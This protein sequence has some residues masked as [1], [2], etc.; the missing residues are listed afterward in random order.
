M[1]DLNIR[2]GAQLDSGVDAKIQKQL[3]DVKGLHL[4]VE[5]VT[6]SGKALEKIQSALNNSKVNL[7]I[8]SNLNG[9]NLQKQG[10]QLGQT[11]GQQITSG[12]NNT[13][14][15]GSFEK[16]FNP[17]SINT[18]A[19]EA[20]KYFQTIS[21]SVSVTENLGANNN[22][23]SFIVSLKNADGVVE[24]L[25]YNLQTLKDDD[26][27][28]TSKFFQYSGGNI[29]DN[30]VIQQ[31]TKI[32]AKADDLTLKLDKVKSAYSDINSPKAVK[33]NQHVSQLASQYDKVVQS[34]GSLR[35]ADDST[36]SA[37]TANVNKEI[38]SL[39][40]M[41][42]QF[43]NAEYAATS[44]R[45]KDISTIKVD[46][47][48]SLNTFVEKM[49]QS[50]N[51]TVD[52]QNKV[53]G[54]KTELSKVFDS[55]S[56]TG[57]LNKLSN[58][59]SEFDSVN[60]A[61]NTVG[62]AT[63]LQT[64]VDME[65]NKLKNLRQELESNGTITDG[66]R[67]KFDGLETSLNKV[68]TATG[69]TT[70]RA[71]MKSVQSDVDV[72]KNKFNELANAEKLA[73]QKT[74]VKSNIDEFLST[75]T[76]LTGELRNRFLELRTAID[77]VDDNKALA[78]VKTQLSTLK[79]EA[80]SAGMIGKSLGDTFKENI[81][82]FSNWFGIGTLVAGSVRAL[83]NM[84]QS[85]YDIDTAMTSL[86]KVTDETSQKY[87]QF[88]DGATT[89]AQELGRSVSSLVEQ[90]ATWAKLGFGIDDAAKLAQISSIYANVGEVDDNA[91]VSDLVTAM[92]AF[93]IQASDSITIVD[94]LN[95]LGNKFA[96]DSASLGEGLKNSASA[97][98][99][100]G[101]DIN[102]SLAMITGGTEIVQ[103]ASEMGNALKVLSM[104]V[105]G[106]KGE[107]EDLGEEYENVDSI[108]KI[109]TQILNRTGG[110]VNI[111]DESGNFKSTYEILKGI[112]KVWD[113]ISQTD[114]ASL[115]EVIAGKQRGNQVAAL[116]QSFQSG[117]VDKALQASMNSAGS[118]YEEQS[119][120]MESLDAKAQQYSASFQSLSQT[121]LS[122]DFLKSLVD[123]GTTFNNV[124]SSIIQTLGLF[125]SAIG[126]IGI[127]A[128]VKSFQNLKM[129]GTATT[130]LKEFNTAVSSGSA[131]N[132]AYANILKTVDSQTKINVISQSSLTE[133]QKLGAM[134]SAGLGAEEIKTAAST[135]VL[136]TAQ[137]TAK[138]STL[139]FSTALRGLWATML[140]NPLLMIGMAVTA[141]VA[142]WNAYKQS[143]EDMRQKT[144]EAT[145]SFIESSKSVDEYA[146]RY[147]AL[148]D[149]LVNT[150][151]TEER[152]QQIKSELLSIQKE[153]NDKYGEEHGKLNLVTDAY[154]DQ[155]EA[156][157][158]LNKA[159][160]QKFLN[161]NTKG[162]AD[163]ENQM[164]SQKGYNIFGRDVSMYSDQGRDVLDVAKR[165]GL[166]TDTEESTGAFTIRLNAD[167]TTAYKQINDFMNEVTLLQKKYGKDDSLIA[168]ILGEASP[169]LNKAKTVIDKFGE[170]YKSRLSA[171]IQAS[172]NEDLVAGYN[173]AKAAVDKYNE[174]VVSGD[175]SKIL[176]ARKDLDGVKKSID[177]TSDDWKRYG[178]IMT[179]VFNQADTGLYDFEDKI[180]ANQDGLKG[181]A[182]ELRG[183]SEEDLLAMAD[184]GKTDTFDK[185]VEY[186]KKYG[187]NAE[188]VIAVL[189]RLNIVQGDV[190]VSGENAF[191]PLSKGELI[192][193][194]NSLSGGFESLD[195]IMNSMSG[196]NPFDYALLDD[197]NFKKAFGGLGD[198]Y[199][200]FIEKIS[201]S[202]KDVK[203][204]QSA[205]DDLV[206]TWINS[207]GVLDGLTSDN[208]SLATAMLKNMGVANAEQVVTAS[209][210]STQEH[211]AAQKAYTADMS[212]A[213]TNA[214][215]SE[216]P[217]LID[218]ATQSDIAKVAIAGLALEKANVNGTTLDTSGDIENV[219]SLIGVIGTASTALQNYNKLKSGQI[220]DAET[221]KTNR[222]SLLSGGFNPGQLG[223]AAEQT[224]QLSE[225]NKKLDAAKTEAQKEV[226]NAI[227]SAKGYKGK[228]T[229]ANVS[230]TGGTKTNKSSGSGSKKDK[231]AFKTDI[232]WTEILIDRADEKF[233]KLQDKISDA[234]N[235]K[236]KN[237]LTDTAIDEMANKV[238]ALE[239]TMDSYQKKADSYD[240]APSYIE[241]IKNGTM[242]IETITDETVSNNIKSYQEWYNKVE[243]VRKQIDSTKKSMK[244]LA[245]S[246]LDNIIND[247]ESLVSLSEKYSSYSK[248]LLELQKNLG[249]EISNADYENLISQQKG[250]Y[251]QLENEYN[252]LS[253]ALSKAV[254]TGDI[255]VGTKEWR[256]Y[257]GELIDVSNSM[258]DAVSSMNDFRQAMLD[259]SFKGIEDFADTVDRANNSISTMSDLI[260]D[261]GLI[262]KGMVT[263]KGLAKIALLGQQYANAKQESAEYA[264][265]IDAV[266]EA[267]ANG[268]LT[269]DEYNTRLNEYTSSQ[270]S[271]VKATKE[272]E[273]AILQFRK[274][275]IQA[276]ID[277]MDE[278]IAKKKEAKQE[279]YDYASYLDELAEKQ[280]T[281]SNIQKKL[282][283]LTTN[284]DPEDSYA[285]SQRIQLQKDLADAQKDLDKTQADHSLEEQLK[286][287]DQEGENY[288][289]AKNNELD[290]LENNYDKQQKVISD[291]LSDVKNN[292]DTVY[293]TLTKYGEDY[294]LATTDD[295]T[296]P[297]E[298]AS[299][300]VDTFQSA[301]GDAIAQINIDIAS[302]DLSSLTELVSMMQGVSG[303]S[304]GSGFEDVTGR[305]TWQK[306]SKG[307][308]YGSS[309]DDYVS[310]GIYTIGGKQYS[311][312]EDGYVK[313][314]WDD[315]TDS[316]RY[317]DPENGQMVKSTWRD[318]KGKSYYL[319]SDGTMA[320]DMAIKAK[321]GSGYYYVDEE[322]TWDG[323]TLS[324][325][326]V[327]RRNI[328]VGYAS[329][330]NDAK[331]GLKYVG[332]DEE[333]FIFTPHGTVL[334]SNGHEVIFNG[335]ETATLR[336]MMANPNGYI[337]D[338]LMSSLPTLDTT[339]IMPN[340]NCISLNITSPLVTIEGGLDS[341][342]KD[343]VTDLVNGIPGKIVDQMNSAY[344]TKGTQR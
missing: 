296:S 46:E 307:D 253:K 39:E 301:V 245:Q 173:D 114:Q 186:A 64:N 272:A 47:G 242:E 153:L 282:N 112:S 228:G 231:E 19:K 137:T 3:N 267:Y 276:Q 136:T 6:L 221:Q 54:L 55:N 256:K 80:K 99:L 232:D 134:S 90:T 175:E 124:L 311:F 324:Y 15:R 299:G 25:R 81:S 71:E 230:Y 171:E 243:E 117:Q 10:Q 198:S 9:A 313:T 24:K 340:N 278:L 235:Y 88:L 111:F 319:K 325:D 320:A 51:Y 284:S 312:N 316:W 201:N 72:T 74:N 304:S 37:M 274:D 214:T 208:A 127:G 93:N 223:Q 270:L 197:G 333:E 129:A 106:M 148:H 16:I 73:L 261:E 107:L 306:T 77:S 95:E 63:K 2:I 226:D 204:A 36:F 28:I 189:K 239:A 38:S 113:K 315:S 146:A 262:D 251:S 89:K 227:K 8:Q 33:D 120:W 310:D 157:K 196:K 317:F 87:N 182:E 187:L 123:S 220:F 98:K 266:E 342:M 249:E 154:R 48:N 53:S 322:G 329:G 27:N 61:A 211:L 328:E 190:A 286:A 259:I 57:Y 213:L 248:S 14:Q 258:N 11:V 293:K 185:L 265:A 128:F 85:V 246:K 334:S 79:N 210:A 169:E 78:N 130:V 314:G 149:E 176:S 118:A 244:E 109:Q 147:K 321:N 30:G 255:K 209:L 96:T 142:A 94:S 133:K 331:S 199:T 277:D 140:A 84:Y 205:F 335:G 49:K 298:S 101:N 285:R 82:A 327:K 40:N 257:N 318:Y 264:N 200:Q 168:T 65:L 151:T 308:W 32:S 103:N 240:L 139:G 26:G 192:T 191:A 188:G 122:S 23:T 104:R 273:D 236:S 203:S 217:K 158:Q 279:D 341:T 172:N 163:A 283:E 35:N 302:I 295:L 97:L 224:K 162:L 91:A 216:I 56:L 22:L 177:L 170:D 34:I 268:S 280:K 193:N 125:P 121:I 260:G 179:D 100:A 222:E 291:Y 159:T 250:I 110:T 275:A 13:I 271:A 155:T 102:Q 166:N 1:S 207:S 108:S 289:N 52:L 303:G 44:L 86:Y 164:T 238:T 43:K 174:A 212:D 50:G 184:D 336:D 141:G 21:K 343:Y 181:F 126:L 116:I 215:A 68:G 4:N 254:S 288:K 60:A 119:R 292:Y 150:N 167:P 76:K 160:A 58:V 330:T 67:Q 219:I 41:V 105:R 45:T 145:S 161:E 206:T 12:I 195:K 218:E 156:I 300:A 297:W 138:V 70:W 31:F 132:L 59:K 294:N 338:T 66:L 42:K 344:K 17:S 115:L 287:L 337:M 332:E 233:Q 252:S 326:E 234:S 183:L 92:K 180:K 5:N 247:F 62:K 20:E 83:K 18:A 309:N 237:T 281:I 229:N 305:G 339:K 241:K 69:L 178:T 143:I 131:G 144:T 323:N 269:Q 75:N 29:N 263:S 165:L 290:E 135:G 194:L 202:P 225:Y 7:N 152:Q